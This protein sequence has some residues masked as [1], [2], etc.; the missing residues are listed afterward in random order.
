MKKYLLALIVSLCIMGTAWG[1]TN[2]GMPMFQVFDGNGEPLSGGLLETFEPGSSVSKQTYSDVNAT[3]GNANPVVLNSRGEA[4]IYLDGAYKLRLKDSSGTLIWTID[5]FMGEGINAVSGTSGT[6]AIW[7]PSG[8]S[9]IRSAD[10]ISGSSISG[11]SIPSSSMPDIIEES[12]IRTTSD[13]TGGIFLI[14]LTGNPITVQTGKLG[15]LITGASCWGGWGKSGTQA[16]IGNNTSEVTV[17]MTSAQAGMSFVMRN[18]QDTA[19]SGGTINVIFEAGDNIV[20]SSVVTG[21]AGT[22]KYVLS[23]TTMSD[24]LILTSSA[25]SEWEVEGEGV[26]IDW[27]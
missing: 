27:D 1:V 20:T 25:T 23:G 2:I 5:N 18:L 7:G 3:T 6:I 8:T 10:T 12:E 16:Q 21:F 4:R 22:S 13:I 26:T 9:D 11:G 24:K 17:L 15:T 14:N 19:Q